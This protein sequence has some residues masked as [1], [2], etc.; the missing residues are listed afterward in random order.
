MKFRAGL[1]RKFKQTRPALFLFP[2]ISVLLAKN[3]GEKNDTG[4]P[5]FRHIIHSSHGGFKHEFW[6]HFPKK[7]GFQG[8]TPRHCYLFFS[9]SFVPAISKS[10]RPERYYKA[11]KTGSGPAGTD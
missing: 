3:T 9:Q 11:K 2:F 4:H 7:N 1:C 8:D 10:R 5:V 6:G